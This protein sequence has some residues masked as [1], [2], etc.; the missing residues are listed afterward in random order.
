MSTIPVVLVVGNKCGREMRDIESIIYDVVKQD[1]YLFRNDGKDIWHSVSAEESLQALTDWKLYKNSKNEEETK[2]LRD[3]NEQLKKQVN[4]LQ[5]LLE[6]TAALVKQL[7]PEAFASFP[8]PT[9][10]K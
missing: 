8:H 5:D 2:K 10:I 6:K 9:L 3:E 4:I 7:P 1:L